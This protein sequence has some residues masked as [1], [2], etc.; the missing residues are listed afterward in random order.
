MAICFFITL[1]ASATTD[2]SNRSDPGSPWFPHNPATQLQIRN[3]YID[4]SSQLML[5]RFVYTDDSDHKI[6]SSGLASPVPYLAMAK[7]L[8]DKI[9][10][11]LDVTADY[12]VSAK[13]SNVAYGMDSKT[14]A[15]GAYLKP[16][17]SFQ[18]TERLAVGA[19]PIIGIGKFNWDGPF[20]SL[21][22]RVRIRSSGGGFGWHL[23]S[24][25][26]L[27]NKLM[28][29]VNYSS[30]VPVKVSGHYLGI[31][32]PIR[33]RNQVCIKL[34][35]PD[36]LDLSLGYQPYQDWLLVWQLSHFGQT[37]NT[38]ERADLNLSYFP[39]IKS[40]KT[41]LQDN[42]SLQFGVS[43][44]INSIWTIGG[45]ITYL[46]R[47]ATKVADTAIPSSGGVCLS[48]RVKYS[49]SD[50]FSLTAIISHGWGKNSAKKKMVETDIWSLE[51]G[52]IYYF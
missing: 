46:S 26:K 13:F 16:Y 14:L 7:R 38:S 23:G 19:G 39:F 5:P 24:T 28:I 50:N 33:L 20:N 2:I 29:G 42:Y 3:G 34:D 37:P 25:Y 36:R 45:G 35:L 30:V 4:S 48:G 22:L 18:L 15:F 21:P 44:R 47:P 10:I 6:I 17:F 43:H 49:W 9:V 27:S 11:G 41:N 31:L 40:L 1:S 51:I 12:G 32:G 8:S 52:G